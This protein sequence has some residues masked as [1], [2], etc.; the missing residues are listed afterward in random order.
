MVF[1]ETELLEIACCHAVPKRG[2]SL[3]WVHM[4]LRNA[5]KGLMLAL[6]HGQ[7]GE[8][9]EWGRKGARCQPLCGTMAVGRGH[10][11]QLCPST[12]PALCWAGARSVRERSGLG[13]L[14]YFCCLG[15]L[16]PRACV[17]G[18]YTLPAAEL[19]TFDSIYY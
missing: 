7:E 1:L 18:T 17:Q 2:Q 13:V 8:R 5:G 16:T 10:N 6:N 15:L 3:C 19:N 12:S 11:A 14:C 9:R 4:G